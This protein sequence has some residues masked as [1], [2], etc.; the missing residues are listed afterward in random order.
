MHVAPV[1]DSF[2]KV[3]AKR[4]RN[5]WL[6][7]MLTQTGWAAAAAKNSLFSVRYQ[8]VKLRRGGQRAVIAIGHAQLI[9]IYWALR[10]GT[11]YRNKSNNWNRTGARL[12]SGT[13]YSG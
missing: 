12:R 2:F 6:R 10:N 8:R 4:R 3:P 11:P 9:A 5:P 1:D 7:G 13:I